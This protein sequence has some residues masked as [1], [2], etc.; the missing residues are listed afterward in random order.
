MVRPELGT[1]AGLLL[2]LLTLDAQEVEPTPFQPNPQAQDMPAPP[3]GVEMTQVRFTGVTAFPAEELKGRLSEQLEG[4]RSAGLTPAR[5]DDTAFF[6]AVYYRKQGYSQVEVREEITPGGVLILHVNEGPVTYVTETNFIGND[7]IDAET[8]KEYLLGATRE[9]V[10]RFDKKIPYIEGDILTGVDRIRGLYLSEGFLD[11][12]IS[13]PETKI[14]PDKKSASITVRIS[15]G[16]HYF[17]GPVEVEGDLVFFPQE[18][19]RKEIAAFT[20]KPYTLSRVVNLRRAVVYYYKTRGYYKTKVTTSGDP[21]TAKD[22]IVP[23]SVYVT[24]GPPYTF[25][26]V[27]VAGVER[28]RK[29]FLEKRFGKLTGDIYNPT[30]LDEVFKE[31]MRTGLFTRLQV[32]TEPLDS[33]QV[34]IKLQVEE[35]KAKELGFALGYGTFEGPFVGITATERNLFGTGRPIEGRLEVSQRYYKSEILFRDPWFL[36]S[37][38][39]LRARLYALSTDFD[40]YSKFEIGGRLALSRKL[41]DHL[42]AMGFV[43]ARNV[44]VTNFGID[45][46][47]LGP[48]SYRANSVGLALTFDFR[49]TLLNPQK[50]WVFTSSIDYASSAV[51]SDI[52][53]VRGTYRF[54]YYLPFGKTLLAF[55]ARGGVIQPLGGLSR[56]PID[57]RFFNGGSRSVRSFAERE[58]GPKD[59]HHFPIGG[60]NF[61]TYNVEFI[62]PIVGDLEGAVFFDAGSVGSLS[63]QGFSDLRYGIGGGLRYKLPVGPLRLDYGW[64]PS[65]RKD[66]ATGAFH[67]SF[68]VAF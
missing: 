56:L 38:F 6:L 45:P 47:E 11:S 5:A 58:L 50:G 27:E 62:F 33:H 3:P 39:A 55:G 16:T 61:S 65:P 2:P 25:D 43:L 21:S 28:L 30:A 7:S 53:F 8:L 24:A 67:F 63:T 9:R 35:A 22:G 68:G 29:S 12:E 32:N 54:S 64:N 52:N 19:L 46:K 48:T 14:S 34:R 59:S 17:I 1:L 20:D 15:E 4:I 18:D 66:E 42:E 10:S 41:T 49:D 31:M 36:E 60:Q 13:K 57:E 44:D 40:G 37:D 23:I 26:G 51:G